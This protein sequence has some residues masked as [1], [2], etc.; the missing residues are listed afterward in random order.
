MGLHFEEDINSK[1]NGVNYLLIIGIDTYKHLPKLNNCVRDA[2]NISEVLTGRYQFE[3]E[4][5]LLLFNENATRAII[6]E[7]LLYLRNVLTENDSL[8]VYYAGHGKYDNELNESYILPIDAMPNKV[9]TWL[10]LSVVLKLLNSYKVKHILFMSD[11]HSSF[12]ILT[13][14]RKL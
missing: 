2:K 5:L 4:H 14:G 1:N 13:H 7:T 3:P 9:Y 6:Y 10:E 11:S 8:L 12:N